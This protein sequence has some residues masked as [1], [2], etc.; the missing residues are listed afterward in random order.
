[1]IN[2]DG[3]A[4]ITENSYFSKTDRDS[5]TTNRALV[6]HDNL[7]GLSPSEKILKQG[8]NLGHNY[9]YMWDY[10]VINS[11]DYKN[12]CD[13]TYRGPEPFSEPETRAVRDLILRERPKSAIFYHGR[14]EDHT[15][16]IIVPYVSILLVSLLC[17][18]CV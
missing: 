12:P 2:P 5:M 14:H 17:F 3:W 13:R 4:A 16:R 8:V 10:P 18:Y 11:G 7:D 15:S 1:M 6:C 9:G